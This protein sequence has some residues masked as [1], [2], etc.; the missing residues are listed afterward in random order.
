MQELEQAARQALEV[1]DGMEQNHGNLWQV[2]ASPEE[3]DTLCVALRAALEQPAADR[4]SDQIK[5]MNRLNWIVQLTMK[6]ILMDT[7]KDFMTVKDAQMTES[8]TTV[9]G[10]DTKKVIRT[11][12]T[13]E[14]ET[15]L[16]DLIIWPC[17]TW[18]FR[19][20]LSCFG[21]KS[22]DYEVIPFGC[23]RYVEFLG[24]EG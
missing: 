23:T 15:S 12:Y 17:G 20:D 8:M 4:R 13:S 19:E 1:L 2:N 24:G 18:C 3:L 6:D 5:S 16:E 7:T 21:H 10:E 22:D 14:H 11:G 9:M